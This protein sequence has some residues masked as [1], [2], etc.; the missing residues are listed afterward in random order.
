[1][2]PQSNLPENGNSLDYLNSIAP[3]ASQRSTLGFIKGPLKPVHYI[4]AALAA[5]VVIVIILSIVLNIVNGGVNAK[6]ERLSARTQATFTITEAAKE[7]IKSADLRGLNSS[8]GLYLTD[9]NNK[10]IP[11]LKSMG[12]TTTKLPANVR[13]Q[14]AGKAITERLE[15][16]YFNAIY[17]STYAREM[18]YQLSTI[19]TLMKEI[20]QSTN[21]AALKTLLQTSYASLEPTQAAFE[22]F[23][24]KTE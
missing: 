12:I 21:N 7:R 13:S 2:G 17:D 3:T 16:A 1:M 15:D 20:Y 24:T 22:A 19:L 23:T 10:L 18:A 5:L 9:I 6:A 4:F 8:L 11:P 14:E